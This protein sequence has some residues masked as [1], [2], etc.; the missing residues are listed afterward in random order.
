MTSLAQRHEFGRHAD[1]GCLAEGGVVVKGAAGRACV[2][3]KILH[4]RI[5]A[6]PADLLGQHVPGQQAAGRA[7]ETVEVGRALQHHRKPGLRKEVA[8]QGIVHHAHTLC[9]S[10][11]NLHSM[12][13]CMPAPSL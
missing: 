13:R 4:R 7:A 6:V 2:G 11:S 8:G 1:G 3:E 9:L 12:V 10:S 5:G